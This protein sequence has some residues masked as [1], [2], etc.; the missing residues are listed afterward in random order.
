MYVWRERE[1]DIKRVREGE[2]DLNKLKSINR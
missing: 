2:R 1:K